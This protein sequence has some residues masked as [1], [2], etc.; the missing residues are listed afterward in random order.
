[1]AGQQILILEIAGYISAILIGTLLGMIGGGGSILTVPV[2]VYLFGIAPVSATAYSLFIVGISSLL[3]ALV[4]FRKKQLSITTAVKFGVPSIV[5]VYFSRKI[6]LPA[7]PET[8]IETHSYILSKDTFIMVVF[9]VLMVLASVSMIRSKTIE[10]EESNEFKTKGLIIILEGLVVGVLTGLVGA[11]GGFLIIPA[12][13]LVLKLPMQTAIGTSLAIIAA[14]SLI[15]FT[16]DLSTQ[17][18]DWHFLFVFSILSLIGIIGG[19]YL[20]LLIN[21]QRLK[22][23]FGWFVLI[24][25][26]IIIIQELFNN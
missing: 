18:I 5:A 21:S 19:T 24:S 16:G 22:K 14:K 9:A 26:I 23:A 10:T 17:T 6:L 7:I 4:A 13:V 2:L 25:G 1:M 20:T 12:L 8:I 3:G 11:G 15:G